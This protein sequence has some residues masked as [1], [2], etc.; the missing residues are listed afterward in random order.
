MDHEGLKRH[1]HGALRHCQRFWQRAVAQSHRHFTQSRIA[2]TVRFSMSPR[3]LAEI[4]GLR[5]ERICKAASTALLGSSTV[6]TGTA[7]GARSDDQTSSGKSL[8]LAGTVITGPVDIADSTGPA[9]LER[10][11]FAITTVSGIS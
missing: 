11:I 2:L 7:L 1:E 3:S 5:P 9:P 10:P 6:M 8:A 4:S